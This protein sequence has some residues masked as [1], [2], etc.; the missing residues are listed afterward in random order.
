ME[1][2]VPIS[3]NERQKR[4]EV[5]LEQIQRDIN[6]LDDQIKESSQSK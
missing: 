4:I 3:S 5:D 6:S 1:N 2:G